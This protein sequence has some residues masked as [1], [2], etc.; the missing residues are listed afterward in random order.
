MNKR[1]TPWLPVFAL[2]AATLPPTAR[3]AEAQDWTTEADV[4]IG[5]RPEAG[6][7]LWHVR[8]VRVSRNGSR[9]YVTERQGYG[10]QAGLGRRVTVWLPDGSLLAE[11][12]PEG[13]TRDFG[14]PLGIR[15][16]RSGF[17]VRFPSHLARFSDG[18]SLVETI[19]HPHVEVSGG[20]VSALAVLEDR[21]LMAVTR[22]SSL[23][24]RLGWSG[25]EPDTDEHLLHMTPGGDG[26]SWDTIADLD[27][28]NLLLGVR[29]RSRSSAIPAHH[30]GEQPFSDTD[31]FYLDP[32]SGIAGVVTRNGAPGEVGL[33]ETTVRGE[34]TW[35]R[36]LE[37]P[38]VAIPA[39]MLRRAAEDVV[40]GITAS[41][42]SDNA[43]AKLPLDSLRRMVQNALHLPSHRPPV[44][45]AIATASGEVWLRSAESSNTAIVWYALQRGDANRP[46]RRV[47]VPVWFRLSDATDSH[48]W[49][50]RAYQEGAAPV[51]GRRLVP[52]G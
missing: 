3:V 12:G 47:V 8:Q 15:L 44:I 18:G 40:E 14:A 28:S 2:I 22:V 4:E 49:G 38:A 51:L 39:D 1:R 33:H 26:W 37:L 16:A 17:W 5:G 52:P 27:R 9:I 7:T 19:E 6:A 32:V 34:T 36:H 50:S 11:I 25:G 46:P 21:S 23:H 20:S 29:A 48:V 43:L 35:R 13:G 30:F 42:S 41:P 31:L 24:E 45:S 10:K